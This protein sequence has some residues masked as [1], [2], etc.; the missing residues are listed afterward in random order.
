MSHGQKDCSD[1]PPHSRAYTH[2]SLVQSLVPRLD[3][4]LT[5]TSRVQ[6]D[7]IIAV[8]MR[9]HVIGRSTGI[10]LSMIMTMRMVAAVM[11]VVV[12]VRHG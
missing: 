9:E 12:V 11:A 3:Y 7:D 5:L 6:R 10:C 2:H 1:I 8:Y 4:F